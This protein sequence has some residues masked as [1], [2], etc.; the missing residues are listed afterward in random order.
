MKRKKTKHLL[1]IIIQ[2]CKE[3]N[4]RR[5]YAQLRGIVKNRTKIERNDEIYHFSS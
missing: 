4:D 5:L 2:I 1:H 3:N